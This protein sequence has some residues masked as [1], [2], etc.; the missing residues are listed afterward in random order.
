MAALGDAGKLIV[1]DFT[2]G[3]LAAQISAADTTFPVG[4]GFDA[5]VSPAF[6]YIVLD[7]GEVFGASEVVKVTAHT[8]A[9]ATGTIAR[10]Q[11]GT[12]ARIHPVGTLWVVSFIQD[13]WD[14]LPK[15][16]VVDQ[17]IASGQTGITTITDVTSSSISPYLV[18][19]RKYRLAAIGMQVR[20]ATAASRFI[21]EF[22]DVTGGS[23]AVGRWYTDQMNASDR[24]L[25]E[26][27][28]T[29]DAPATGARNFKLTFERA[30]GTGT[31][32]LEN[33]TAGVH[34]RFIVEDIGPA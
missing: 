2:K 28:T 17:A 12:T 31:G 8:A 9:A 13:M 11:L 26:G 14:A 1:P 25:A 32:E 19:G 27:S 3:F 7:P 20:C 6:S 5:V 30:S 23:V 29:Y 4:T 21:G 24:N 22:V 34:P 15:G 18:N 10:A 33:N 16:I